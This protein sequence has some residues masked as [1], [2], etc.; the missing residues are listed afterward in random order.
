MNGVAFLLSVVVLLLAWDRQRLINWRTARVYANVVHLLHAA[1]GFWGVW[2]ACTD[3]VPVILWILLLASVL[4]LLWTLHDWKGGAP[5]HIQ[6]RPADLG[7][8]ELERYK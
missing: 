6:T 5:R 7:P 4:W 2:A 8:P 1:V 3:E